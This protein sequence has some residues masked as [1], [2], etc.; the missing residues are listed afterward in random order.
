[1]AAAAV[2]GHIIC[3]YVRTGELKMRV[4]IA[5]LFLV[6]LFNGNALPEELRTGKNLRQEQVLLPLT[7][8][9]PKRMTAVDWY[10]F[11]EEDG[12]AGI[13]IYYDDVLTKRE[14]DY[15][16]LYDVEGDLLVVAWIDRFGVYHVAM[17]RGLVNTDDPAVDGTLVPV[18]LGQGV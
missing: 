12:S 16:E 9:D 13:L 2:G 17:D 10:V 8:P 4:V 3:L 18:S 1:V 5:A 6:V 11:L 7:T 15:I 14:I